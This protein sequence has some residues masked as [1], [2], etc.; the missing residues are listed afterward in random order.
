MK[1]QIPLRG[2]KSTTGAG[3]DIGR[4]SSRPNAR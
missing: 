3:S 1:L 2:D 4:E